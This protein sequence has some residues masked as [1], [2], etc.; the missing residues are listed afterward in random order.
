MKLLIDSNVMISMCFLMCFDTMRE[1]YSLEKYI[2][3]AKAC[4]F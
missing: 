4:L 2:L 3:I 1:N